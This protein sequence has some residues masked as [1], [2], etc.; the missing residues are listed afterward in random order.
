ML[1]LCDFVVFEEPL[2]RGDLPCAYR[3]TQ[4]HSAVDRGKIGSRGVTGAMES[5]PTKQLLLANA[6]TYVAFLVVNG[7]TQ[8]G[9]IGEDNGSISAKYPT[10]ITPAPWAFSIWGIIFIL[11]VGATKRRR[12]YYQFPPQ[13]RQRAVDHL[14]EQKFLKCWS[15]FIVISS[16]CQCSPESHHVCL[17]YNCTIAGPSC[18]SNSTD[19]CPQNVTTCLDL[20]KQ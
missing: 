9:L 6:V 12:N 14:P 17:L 20:A 19:V 13:N 7:V 8:S 5:K 16:T 11:Q 1:E 3:S 18:N 2:H 10:P 15:Y 4:L